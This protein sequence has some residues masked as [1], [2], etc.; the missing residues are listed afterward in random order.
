METGIKTEDIIST[1]QHLEMIKFWKGQHVIFVNQEV[2]D[3]YMKQNKKLRLCKPDCLHWEPP[4]EE[5]K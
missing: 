3:E 2:I 4:E 5:A 1:L